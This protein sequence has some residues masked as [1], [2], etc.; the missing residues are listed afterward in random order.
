MVVF[1]GVLV[2]INT[3][4]TQMFGSKV[5]V[6]VSFPNMTLVENSKPAI[7]IMRQ[8]FNAEVAVVF[9]NTIPYISSGTYN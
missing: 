7:L 9:A 6:C 8:N 5:L 1:W 4:P 2:P 3:K